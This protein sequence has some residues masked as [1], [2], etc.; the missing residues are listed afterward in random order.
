MKYIQKTPTVDA[1]RFNG[2][3]SLAEIKA[4][5]FPKALRYEESGMGHCVLLIQINEGEDH[6]S[7][8]RGDYVVVKELG[9]KNHV[10]VLSEDEFEAKYEPMPTSEKI[11]YAQD[12]P[13]INLCGQPFRP[14]MDHA[15]LDP[16]VCH[17]SQSHGGL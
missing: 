4:L 10:V 6:L 12:V 1:V 11:G 17:A 8:N 15:V 3:R 13:P 9:G 5:C 14:K 2:A 16:A 7:V